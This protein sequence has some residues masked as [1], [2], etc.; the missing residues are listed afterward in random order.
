MSKESMRFKYLKYQYHSS[1]KNINTLQ[2][3]ILFKYQE[4]MLF[5][6]SIQYQYFQVAEVSIRSKYQKF[7][8][9]QVSKILMRFKY[10]KYQ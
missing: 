2:V 7:N 6:P 4:V 8:V 3:S 9:F 5:Q 1:I 10:Q